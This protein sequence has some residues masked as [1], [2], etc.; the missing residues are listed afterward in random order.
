M[1]KT[2]IEK[3]VRIKYEISL[4][5]NE[6]LNIYDEN[7]IAAIKQLNILLIIKG[8]V[9]DFKEKTS[10]KPEVVTVDSSN[11]YIV[12]GALRKQYPDENC[13]DDIIKIKS[14]NLTFKGGCNLKKNVCILSKWKDNSIIMA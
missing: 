9:K 6:V 1:E 10:T 5:V 8:F 13:Y 7:E 12:K 14:L 4:P 11:F 3:G 2:I